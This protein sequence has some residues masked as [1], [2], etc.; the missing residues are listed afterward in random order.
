MENI[1]NVVEIPSELET[2]SSQLWDVCVDRN[3]ALHV[4]SVCDGL[5]LNLLT[6]SL[7]DVTAP[8]ITVS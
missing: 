1:S 7:N 5:V 4:L 3:M 2:I 8:R 6:Y